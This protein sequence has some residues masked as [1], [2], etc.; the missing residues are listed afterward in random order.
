MTLSNT[1]LVTLTQA[2]NFLKIDAT[3]SL[4]IDAEYVDTG[5]GS[6]T[7]FTLDHTPT[8]GSLKLY[9]DNSLLTETTHYTISG[10]AL[11]FVVYP[12][13][14]E[15]ITASYDYAASSD[16]FESYDDLQLEI[17]I[18]AATNKAEDYCGRAFIQRSITENHLGDGLEVLRLY[19]RPV[20][21]ITSVS[22]EKVDD[23]EGDGASVNFT[24]GETPLAGSYSVSVAGVLKTET[25][26]YAISGTTL[27]FVAAPADEALVI[28]RYKVELIPNTD[29][30]EQLSIGRLKGSW[31]TDYE[32]Q[33]IYTAGYATTRAATQALVN[34]AVTAVLI[35]VANWWENRLGLTAQSISGIG[36]ANYTIG[37]LPDMAKKI[38]GS[39]KVGL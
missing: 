8:E 27:T 17:L 38:L 23:F 26:H 25:T 34:E 5:N 10:A 14:G 1:V 11:T 4:H 24:L 19:K 30:T 29:Y 31:E 7:H 9:L 2:K 35:T 39:L 15:V 16:T 18:D 21:S 37:E 36:S 12:P 33:V 6:E 28:V 20:A 32:Y 13:N 22:Y 3:A